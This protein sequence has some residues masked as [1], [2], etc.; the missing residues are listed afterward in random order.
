MQCNAMQ[1][2]AM[3]CSTVQYSTVQYSTVQYSTVQYSTIQYNKIQYILLDF[4]VCSI[5]EYFYELR[6][7]LTSPLGRVKV[8]KRNLVTDRGAT[9]ASILAVKPV[10]CCTITK[11][12]MTNFTISWNICTRFVR[13]LYNNSYSWITEYNTIQCN[14]YLIGH[15][16]EQNNNNN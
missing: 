1:Y 16:P 4:L 5:V 9:S 12:T 3:Q 13:F 6:C 15:S 7:I 11:C 14:A 10:L 8:Q 2:N